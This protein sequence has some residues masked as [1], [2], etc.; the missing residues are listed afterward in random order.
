MNPILMVPFIIAPLVNVIVSYTFFQL[1]LIPMIMAKLP[2][3]V[4]SPIAAVI[5][6]NWTIMAGVL[7]LLNF[8]ISLMIYFSI[9]SRCSRSS[10]YVMKNKIEAG[11][12]E[13]KAGIKYA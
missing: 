7:V 3:T 4:F 1:G 12:E 5:S 13:K 6:T 9:F 2:F 10:I 8:V 11:P